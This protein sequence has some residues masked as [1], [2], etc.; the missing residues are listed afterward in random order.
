MA[1]GSEQS[2]FGDILSQSEVEQLLAQ[3]V[4]QESHLPAP[5]RASEV[6]SQSSD[7]VRIHDFRR[8]AFLSSGQL[9]KLRWH[10]EEIVRSLAASLSIYLRLEFS[11]KMVKLQTLTDQKFAQNLHNPTHLTLFKMEP[12][13]GIGILDI[14]PRLG[15]C[16]VDRLLGGG[17]E[18]VSVA[19]DLTE[20]EITLLDQA[21]Q[22]IL[23]EWCNH[24]SQAHDL[25]PLILG[26]EAS[27]HF[28]QMDAHDTIMLVVTMQ[29]RLG[30]C[31]EQ[32]QIAIPC[33]TLETLLP[34]LK[35]NLESATPG[36]V[37]SAPAESP[38]W[39]ESFN[40][41]L[42]PLTAEWSELE[43]RARDLSQ[44]KVGD[45]LELDSQSVNRVQVRL[46]DLLK[47]SGRLGTCDSKW[48]VELAQVHTRS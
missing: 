2:G 15:L 46:G 27:G 38:K 22:I 17:S 23:H 14:H 16:L 12:L 4:Q 42:I 30:D 9:R 29:A 8:P 13:R 19:H 5:E 1:Q 32:M 6:E 40:D 20:I 48:A 33:Y 26:H 31:S 25:R 44:L 41:I 37:A 3:V 39:N 34:Q 45:V 36:Q 11:L 7:G 28:L 10:Y 18:S 47:F 43:L 35:Q 24:W 21:V